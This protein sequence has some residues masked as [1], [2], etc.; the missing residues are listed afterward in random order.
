MKIRY[1][2][3]ERFKEVVNF[4]GLCLYMRLTWW[5]KF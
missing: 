1:N 4:L 2:K 5:N 3:K